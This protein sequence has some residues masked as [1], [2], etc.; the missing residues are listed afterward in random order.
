MSLKPHLQCLLEDIMVARI[1][2]SILSCIWHAHDAWIIALIKIDSLK[3][4]HIPPIS[5]GEPRLFQLHAI[6]WLEEPLILN[7]HICLGF[8]LKCKSGL[9]PSSKNPVLIRSFRIVEKGCI[10]ENMSVIEGSGRGR[11]HHK[12]I[13]FI[14]GR[15]IS[16]IRSPGRGISISITGRSIITIGGPGRGISITIAGRSISTIRSSGRGISIVGR[17]PRLVPTYA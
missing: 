2:F 14:A 1:W 15:N 11:I 3:F 13:I 7:K 16:A 6:V 4:V 8:S 12:Q 10:H 9:S 17:I 5:L